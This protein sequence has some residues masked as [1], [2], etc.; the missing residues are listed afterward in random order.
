MSRGERLYLD[1]NASAPLLPEARAA[2]VA[3]LDAANPSSVH[4]EGRRARALVENARDELA[5]LLSCN[6]EHVTFTS[7]ASEAATTCLSPRWLVDGA[8]TRMSRLAVID[9]DHPCIRDGASFDPGT[10]T[11]LPVDGNGLVNCEA[12]AAWAD[13]TEEGTTGLLALTL[14][15]SETGV[16]QPMDRILAAIAGQ[17]VRLVID[18]VQVIGRTAFDFASSG[19]DAAFVSGH[20]FGAA[21]GVGALILSNPATRPF[22]LV[23]GGGQESGR[24]AGTTAVPAIA[25]LGAAARHVRA[26]LEQAP[27]ELMALRRHLEAELTARVSGGTILGG[28]VPRLPNTVAIASPGLRG[29][30]AQIGLDLAGLAVSAGSACS[31]GKVGR[32]HVVDAMVA[33]GLD[34]SADDGA[35]RVSFGY[36]TTIADLDRFVREY[37]ALAERAAPTAREPRAA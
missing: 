26:R 19:A 21:K 9:T 5:R 35:I 33:G 17:P 4:S 1:H 37:A 32:S 15:N 20:K 28:R 22:P 3:S 7:G 16:L 36:E 25:S 13:G 8:E 14:A 34:I 12:L 10:V 27:D 11:R 23:R 2:L 31:S 24:R 30:T 18:A 29:E 6:R